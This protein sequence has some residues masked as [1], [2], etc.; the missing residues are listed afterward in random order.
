[1]KWFKNIKTKINNEKFF[2]FNVA[3]TYLMEFACL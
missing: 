3:C 1:M 2:E